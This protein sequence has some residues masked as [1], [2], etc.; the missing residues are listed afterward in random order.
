MTQIEELV[1][2]ATSLADIADE[3][4]HTTVGS[5]L[6]SLCS[7]LEAQAAQLESFMA[8]AMSDAAVGIALD[9][10]WFPPMS[11]KPREEAMRA[12]ISSAIMSAL[13]NTGGKDGV[14]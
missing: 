10:Y 13:R 11:S 8:A 1:Q 2:L 4:E 3:Q 5:C 6:R 12:A 7:A 9:T 14:E